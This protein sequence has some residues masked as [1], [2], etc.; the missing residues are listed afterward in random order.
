M[1]PPP[2][3]RRGEGG[4]GASQP[5]PSRAQVAVASHHA[6]CCLM[7]TVEEKGRYTSCRGLLHHHCPFTRSGAQHF[8]SDMFGFFLFMLFFP[9]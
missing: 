3:H 4:G 7:C 1:P 9:F 5:P 6:H 2:T 8:F